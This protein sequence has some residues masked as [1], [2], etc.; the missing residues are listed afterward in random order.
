MASLT[1]PQV[2]SMVLAHAAEAVASGQAYRVA[3]LLFA[4]IV[5]ALFWMA[6]AGSVALAAGVAVTA[7]A[8]TAAGAAI[9]VFLGYV[10]API[11]LR[12]R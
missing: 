1:T 2:R 8:L 12:T 10:C 3:G 6:V 11:M 5:P 7:K 4:S 9:A